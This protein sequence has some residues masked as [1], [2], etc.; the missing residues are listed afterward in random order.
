MNPYSSRG[1]LILTLHII[2]PL[3]KKS[4]NF[5]KLNIVDLAGSEKLK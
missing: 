3:T 1:H 2:R 5:A 4:F